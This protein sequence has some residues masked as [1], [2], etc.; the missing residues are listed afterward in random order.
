MSAVRGHTQRRRLLTPRSA[1]KLIYDYI[2]EETVKRFPNMRYKV[3]GG[4]YFLRCA[5][6]IWIFNQIGQCVHSP[7]GRFVCPALS[8]PEAFDLR[9]TGSGSPL[10]NPTV[11]R[12]LILLS[13]FLQNLGSDLM[14]GDKEGM[15]T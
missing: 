11:R 4:F 8:T 12:S 10:S 9:V 3:I 1:M 2:Q 6:G 7:C 15:H 5:S 13:K 14:F